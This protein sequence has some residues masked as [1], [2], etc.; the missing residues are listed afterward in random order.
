MKPTK[1]AR[2]YEPATCA[3]CGYSAWREFLTEIE[4]ISTVEVAQAMRVS[5][6]L[7]Y[8]W[9]KGQRGPGP[10]T[11]RRAALWLGKEW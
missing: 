9:K 11:L 2:H 4:S 7:V 1:S 6:D 3:K 10:E 8:K 5:R